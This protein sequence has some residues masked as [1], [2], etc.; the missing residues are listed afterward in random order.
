MYNIENEDQLYAIYNQLTSPLSI[1]SIQNI[2][3]SNPNNLQDPIDL[4]SL[5][6]IRELNLDYRDGMAVSGPVQ[7]FNIT[8]LTIRPNPVDLV[9][10]DNDPTFPEYSN[11]DF[12]PYIPSPPP[13]M[14]TYVRDGPDLEV[15]V[16]TISKPTPERI[17]SF[18]K[19]PLPSSPPKDPV[20]PGNIFFDESVIQ[21][22]VD[23]SRQFNIFSNE[24][25]KEF[26]IESF[27]DETILY[28]VKLY[29][30]KDFRLDNQ[31]ILSLPLIGHLTLLSKDMLEFPNIFI[32]NVKYLDLTDFH[33]YNIPD[34]S[35]NLLALYT[36]KY[37]H[38]KLNLNLSNY[39]K[40]LILSW[41]GTLI[42]NED[43]MRNFFVISNDLKTF[44]YNGPN[45]STI[46]DILPPVNI[47]RWHGWM[48]VKIPYLPKLEEF[49]SNFVYSDYRSFDDR[50]LQESRLEKYIGPATDLPVT[51]KEIEFTSGG[52]GFISPW[53]FYLLLE[54]LKISE[55]VK[56]M[57]KPSKSLKSYV[58]KYSKVLEP[59]GEYSKLSSLELLSDVNIAGNY[60]LKL[61]RFI[62]HGN[63]AMIN[64]NVLDVTEAFVLDGDN[65]NLNVQNFYVGGGVNVK[66]NL[67]LNFGNSLIINLDEVTAADGDL[68]NLD[69]SDSYG[70]SLE[71]LV[72][73]GVRGVVDLTRYVRLKKVKFGCIENCMIKFKKGLELDDL[74]VFGV[75]GVE[76]RISGVSEMSSDKI[77]V[78][79][80]VMVELIKLKENE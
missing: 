78:G 8:H 46:Q 29:L 26:M 56:I 36:S 20:Q 28:S 31:E 54:S 52:N 38:F 65:I 71:V 21:N 14:W 5:P 27:K 67:V 80:G 10:F 1:P 34:L 75:S 13:P 18:P 6:K 43:N 4:S 74:G 62:V 17:H 22:V 47:T 12:E 77:K 37:D 55:D 73:R 24:D 9:N 66:S 15:P 64:I 53:Q 72:L 2:L 45:L 48:P 41:N 69:L 3:S 50:M 11:D 23:S 68:I 30:S 60:S 44:Y 79:E 35:E 42:S 58:G 70:D 49:V 40:L 59:L 61:D 25:L 63:D 33:C 39:P 7:F 51:I 32:P 57:N 76:V 16:I 19:I